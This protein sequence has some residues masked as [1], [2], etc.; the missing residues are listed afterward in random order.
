MALIIN[1]ACTACDACEPVC[2][3]KAI[4]AGNPMYVI[5]PLKCTE[6]VG[7]EDEPQCKL[8][9]PANCIGPSGLEQS[10]EDLLAKVGSCTADART[11][12]LVVPIPSRNTMS[13]TN[14][15]NRR[16]DEHGAT[17]ADQRLNNC[18][19]A[20]GAADRPADGAVARCCRF[21]DGLGAE[22]ESA[23][24]HSRKTISSHIWR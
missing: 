5:D 1:D 8:V 16:C 6:C 7:A 17:V 23:T 24:L 22:V 3:N 10:K 12:I 20:A 14:Q 18:W 19:R 11:S 13:F 2:P 15:I 9:C 21:G 4:T